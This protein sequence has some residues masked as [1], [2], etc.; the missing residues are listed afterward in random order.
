MCLHT[1]SEGHH[2]CQSMASHHVSSLGPGS[3]DSTT[4]EEVPLFDKRFKL[5][6]IELHCFAEC[7]KISIC[8]FYYP[9]YDPSINMFQKRIHPLYPLSICQLSI[10][11]ASCTH[12]LPASWSIYY[13][14]VHNS[15]SS[16]EHVWSWISCES[17]CPDFGYHFWTHSLY[18]PNKEGFHE[19]GSWVSLHIIIF[20]LNFFSSAHNVVIVSLRHAY[21]RN[22]WGILSSSQ[23]SC[24]TPSQWSVYLHST[25]PAGSIASVCSCSWEISFVY[26][27]FMKQ[28]LCKLG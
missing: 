13:H 26:L 1:C 20:V 14:R 5:K 18:L 9:M 3:A 6:S 7:K 19:D 12:Q 21:Q 2:P 4:C 15:R 25:A 27:S 17:I 16:C 22:N 11:Q 8:L 23:T 10:F 28:V 24:L